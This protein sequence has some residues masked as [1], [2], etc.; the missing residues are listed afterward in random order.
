M[1]GLT[2]SGRIFLVKEKEVVLMPAINTKEFLLHKG[3]MQAQNGDVYVGTEGS[4]VVRIRFQ[5]KEY[6]KGNYETE[7]LSVGNCKTVNDIYEDKE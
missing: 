4:K 3:L 5:G 2:G 1:W 6:L 7:M